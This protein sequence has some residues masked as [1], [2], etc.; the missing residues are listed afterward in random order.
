MGQR[1]QVTQLGIRQPP[2]AGVAEVQALQVGQDG[3][4]ARAQGQ[5]ARVLRVGVDA[6]V[7]HAG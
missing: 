5:A 1:S 7:P 6:Q 3:Q 4:A 2:H